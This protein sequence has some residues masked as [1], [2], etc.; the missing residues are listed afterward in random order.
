LELATL[1]EMKKEMRVAESSV[2]GSPTI[3]EDAFHRTQRERKVSSVVPR[4]EIHSGLK[5]RA[6]L[7]SKNNNLRTKQK[8]VTRASERAR[9]DADAIAAATT[10]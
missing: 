4:R 5:F 9:I 8:I 3:L 2:H 7:L 1:M 6:W 10:P